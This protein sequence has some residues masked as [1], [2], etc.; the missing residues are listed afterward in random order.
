MAYLGLSIHRTESGT[1][2]FL[3]ASQVRVTLF[4]AKAFRRGDGQ[5]IG[6]WNSLQ[7]SLLQEGQAPGTA[8]CLGLRNTNC[9]ITSHCIPNLHHCSSSF[10]FPWHLKTSLFVSWFTHSPSTEHQAWLV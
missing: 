3:M 4:K 8:V 7:A 2:Y 5:E 1:T 9:Q 10:P 6:E